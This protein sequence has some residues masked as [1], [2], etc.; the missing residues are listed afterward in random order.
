MTNP[1]HGFTSDYKSKPN[2]NYITSN[3]NR[4]GS[5]TCLMCSY[6][7][8]SDFSVYECLWFTGYTNSC[9]EV[10]ILPQEIHARMF[11]CVLNV[12]IGLY[13]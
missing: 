11:L 3:E 7:N 1:L 6:Q 13:L 2:K 12:M 8:K 9:S 5:K 10:D 4:S